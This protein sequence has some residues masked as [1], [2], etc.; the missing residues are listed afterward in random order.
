MEYNKLS[1]EMGIDKFVN[2]LESVFDFEFIDVKLMGIGTAERNENRSYFVV[3]KS[4]QLQEVR[5]KYNLP[6]QDFHITIGFKY[7]D[8]FG[9]RKNQIIHIKDPFIKLINKKYYSDNETFK[10]IKNIKNFEGDPDKDLEPIKIE[11]TYATLRCGD[12]D[13]FTVTLI[14][15]NLNISA[16]WQDTDKKP[17]LSQTFINRKLKEI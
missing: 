4:D 14:G 6:E 12:I 9:I 16:K 2:S 1:K 13:Y 8:V 17:I 3:V 10:F 11:D 7:K 15:D 5:K